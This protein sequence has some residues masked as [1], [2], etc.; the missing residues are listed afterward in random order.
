MNYL[1]IIRLD[2]EAPRWTVERAR[3]EQRS[4]QKNLDYIGYR[5]TIS[6][7]NLMA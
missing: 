4:Q 2:K 1:L 7:F 3:K 5:I 6:I